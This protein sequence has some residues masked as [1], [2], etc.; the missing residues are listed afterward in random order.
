MGYA[1][2]STWK[3]SF[4]ALTEAA[5]TLA[6][7]GRPVDAIQTAIRIVEG[8][9]S[10]DT[11]G[12][13][14]LPNR[15]GTVELDAAYMDGDTGLFG[16][17]MG[18]RD[19]EHPI[20]LAVHLSQNRLNSALCGVGAEACARS[21]GFA[22]R[23]MLSANSLSRYERERGKNSAGIPEARAFSRYSAIVRMPA[24]MVDMYGLD[25]QKRVMSR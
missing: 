1:V 23:D 7:D 2:I 14:G 22:M 3:M 10:I 25:R 12:Y 19:V 16:S 6:S 13:G 20:D 9:E 24:S 18:V 5:R 11:V 4:P 21:E 17:V 15:A 8:D